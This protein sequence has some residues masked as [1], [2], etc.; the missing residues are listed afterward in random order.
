MRRLDFMY[1]RNGPRVGAGA[2]LGRSARGR[3]IVMRRFGRGHARTESR[4]GVRLH[5]RHGTRGHGGG[6]GAAPRRLPAAGNANLRL[7][8]NLNPDGY[9]GA[10][11]RLNAH[12]VDLNRN[13]PIRLAADRGARRSRSIRARGRFRSRRPGSRRAVEG[14]S[15]PGVTIWFHQQAGPVVRAGVG[16]SVPGGRGATRAVVGVPSRRMPWMAGTARTGRTTGSPARAGSWWSCRR[17]GEALR[18]TKP[19]ATPRPSRS[20]PAIAARTGWR[21]DDAGVRAARGGT[22]GLSARLPRQSPEGRPPRS[23]REAV[24]AAQSGSQAGG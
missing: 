9:R 23:E 12:G 15:G 16:A 2:L 5:P 6:R 19:A 17:A 18:M 14:C 8:E 24:K 4:A 22:I 20:W 21:C 11:A 7:V 3:P 10:E 1:G 13:F